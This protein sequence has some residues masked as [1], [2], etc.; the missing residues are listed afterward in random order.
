MPPKSSNMLL[1]IIHDVAY[2]DVETK[3]FP[4]AVALVNVEDLA[5]VFDGGGRWQAATM[6][7][8]PDSNIYVVRN[9]GGRKSRRFQFL[10]RIILGLRGKKRADHISGDGLDNRRR[11][12]R[13]ATQRQ[14]VIN[15]RRRAGGSSQYRG[16]SLDGHSMKW[17]AQIADRIKG[18]RKNRYLG[19][20]DMEVDAA[21]A[22]DVAARKL[23]GE[24]ARLNF[25]EEHSGKQ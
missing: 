13:R 11:N 3:K 1:R 5:R 12:L 8:R 20:F 14:N 24:F 21:R 6:N 17:K 23:F 18:R 2:V 4:G 22:Y 16:V 15:S 9:V 25:P 7:D 10:H 19:R